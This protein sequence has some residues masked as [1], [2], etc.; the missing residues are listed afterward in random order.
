M[1][2][3]SSP[4]RYFAPEVIQTSSMD[5]G[6]AALK[7]LLSGCG[8][9][10]SYG[11]LREACQTDLDGTSIDTLE[12]VAREAGL[13][14]EQIL[15]P[16][17]HVL[18]PGARCLPCLAAVRSAAGVA[19]FIVIWRTHG[20]L[21]QIMDPARGRLW[22]TR[23]RLIGQLVTH[24]MTAPA[25]GWLDWSNSDDFLAPLRS[26]MRVL[27]IPSSVQQTHLD[28]A[29]AGG[30]RRVAMLDAAVRMTRSLQRDGGIGRVGAGRAMTGLLQLADVAADPVTVIPEVYWSARPG[31]DPEA[32]LIRGAVMI[33]IK[34]MLSAPEA[35]PAGL[36][37]R[38]PELAAAFN[39][40]PV[41]PMRDVFA[42]MRREGLIG[43]AAATAAVSA[44]VLGVVFEALLLRS[45]VDVK[46][47][48]QGPG[49]AI[50]A[51]IALVVFAGLLLGL[52]C[53]A[54]GT[55]RRLGAHLE[56]RLRMAFLDKLPRLA[57]AYFLS[58]PIADML[59]RSHTLH[60]LRTLPRLC[61]RFGRVGLEL[62]VT[63]LAL[64]WLNPDTMWLAL[65]SC[66]AAALVP[67]MGQSLIAER[68]LRTRTHAGALAKF[69]LDA[70]RG[71]TALEAHDAARAIETEHE[72]LLAEWAASALSLQRT[73][74]AIEGLQM[75]VGFSLAAWM[76]VGHLDTHGT[77]PLLLQA[78]WM[79]NLPGL[80]YELAL[81]AREYPAYRSTII[82]LLEPMGAPNARHAAPSDPVTPSH[83]AS[84]E[85]SL[86][87]VSV[88]V[89]GHA[90]LDRL[91]LDI[92][93]GEHIAI[94]GA[95]G[96][97]KSTL[98][99]LLLGWYRPVTG[100]LLV[101]GAPLLDGHLDS[102][103]ASI[104][105]VDPS[106][107]VWNMS[108]LENLLYGTDAGP[109]DAGAVLEASGLLS[110]VARL[111]DGLATALGEGGALLSAGE[112]QRVR[113]A[114]ALLKTAPRLTLLD[115]PFVGLE[116]E[117]RRALLSHAR[118]RWA[119]TTLLY[120]THD[121]PETRAFD[122][123]LV[124]DRGRIV[125]DGDPYQLAHTP[126]SR[127]RGLLQAHDAM[128]H[129]FNGSEWRRLRMESGRIVHEHARSSEHTA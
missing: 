6:P 48:V 107:H 125:E 73:S 104:A 51:G 110:V 63:T 36:R 115:E 84:A 19:H 88:S 54:A 127:Y 85:I 22:L 92:Q 58:R 70:L 74:I 35:R 42:V 27:G 56:A 39:E 99:G 75:A 103:R 101:D 113:F 55:E 64:I 114:R 30:W 77:A 16:T 46:Q 122:R 57:D 60:V 40:R 93:P 59:E 1:T 71:R 116:R 112:A 82:R 13:D 97:G 128:Q 43:P 45:A 25:A 126:S 111:P 34:G 50:W 23:D 89:S 49:Q 9:Q 79:L 52:E 26:R 90:L 81:I 10:V 87:D 67:A 68:D 44:A 91:T 41:R 14:A 37:A 83:S 17:D 95:S 5:C 109:D 86:R 124:V 8:I 21:V 94:V 53:V 33:R 119:K 121:I 47:M 3:S 31:P 15:V 66:G 105:W 12:E 120:V 24:S 78:Y 65:L 38:S 61:L 28:A 20:A 32:V 11:R 100:T 117:R 123:V 98:I 80:G 96:A 108:L 7:S 76:L 2:P 129:R 29:H 118:Q 106:V 4:R 72:A 62:V 69:H 18:L 102:L